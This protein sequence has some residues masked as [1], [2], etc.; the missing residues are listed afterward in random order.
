[1]YWFVATFLG[2][3]AAFS[4][5]DKALQG[6]PA[7]CAAAGAAE[8]C[9]AGVACGG[10]AP[11]S[12]ARL[13]C[14]RR[15]L[16]LGSDLPREGERYVVVQQ[17][18]FGMA[19]SFRGSIAGGVL[20][21]AL[22]G[23]RIIVDWPDLTRNFGATLPS[24]LGTARAP[25]EGEWW[26]DAARTGFWSETGLKAGGA[27][28]EVFLER[29]R[30]AGAPQ[31]V[32]SSSGGTSLPVADATRD[33]A[34]KLF[35]SAAC[36]E[37]KACLAGALSRVVL[38]EPSEVL[39][40]GMAQ[41]DAAARNATHEGRPVDVTL[42]LHLRSWTPR[43]EGEEHPSR[44]PLDVWG[45]GFFA[46]AAQALA[47]IEAKHPGA[48]LQIHLASDER[49]FR[50]NATENFRGHGAVTSAPDA[51]EVTHTRQWHKRGSIKRTDAGG[52]T[53]VLD[54]FY[55]GDRAHYFVGTRAS[56]FSDGII[57]RGCL[58]KLDTYWQYGSKMDCKRSACD[59]VV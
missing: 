42:G 11:W 16:L 5:S 33:C 21:A 50:R 57:E 7:G 10:T 24:R 23:R 19:N 58:S 4:Y 44:P 27:V 49:D 22:T 35:G 38:A 53:A 26:R 59:K 8:T 28:E 31:F 29:L 32:V 30:V 48:Q 6:E 36:V 3:A 15:E 47:E 55:N 56:T 40:G 54:F 37:K 9:R 1:M 41:I 25:G 52:D 45:R 17:A 34:A 12:D 14:L 46:C 13:A 51:M 43:V 20:V 2:G 39:L 18:G